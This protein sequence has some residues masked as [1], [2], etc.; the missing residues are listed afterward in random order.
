MKKLKSPIFLVVSIIGISLL[1][2]GCNKATTPIPLTEETMQAELIAYLI[3]EDIDDPENP[4]IAFSGYLSRETTRTVDT[5]EFTITLD[6][7]KWP[8]INYSNPLETDIQ[9]LIRYKGVFTY[10]DNNWV[11]DT[12]EKISEE[13]CKPISGMAAE[14]FATQNEVE[15]L[16]QETDLEQG[17]D[18][19]TVKQSITSYLVN[20]TGTLVC[21]FKFQPETKMWKQLDVIKQSDWKIYYDILGRWK[22]VEATAE[23][24]QIYLDI[25]SITDDGVLTATYKYTNNVDISDSVYVDWV[26]K[27]GVDNPF[28]F[29]STDDDITLEIPDSGKTDKL[30]FE[31]HTF[32]R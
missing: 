6:E 14:Q 12:V 8:R 16:N 28:M 21:N 5:V 26:G 31:G 4:P 27:A 22:L 20:Q 3:P 7:Y 15:F 25:T 29:S 19:V 30:V 1:C 2:T 18:K 11:L 13:S 23:R 32:K 24:K 10:K 9:T 17:V